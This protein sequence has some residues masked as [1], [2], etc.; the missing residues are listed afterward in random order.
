MIYFLSFSLFLI[1][2]SIWILSHSRDRRR[3]SIFFFSIVSFLIMLILSGCRGFNVGKDTP[4]YVRYFQSVNGIFNISSYTGR[5]EYFYRIYNCLIAQFFDSAHA[6]LFISTFITL[7][8]FYVTCFK[9]SHV[10][11]YS[12]LM[13]VFL[14]YYYNS[15][16]LLRQYIAMMICCIAYQY[17]AEKKYIKYILTTFIAVLF[18]SSAS[19]TFVLIF[20]TKLKINKKRRIIYIATAI[21]GALCFNKFLYVLIKILPKYASYITSDY[22]QEN[23]MGIIFKIFMWLLMFFLV[24]YM[25]FRARDGEENLGWN[26]IEYFCAL[27]A[28]SITIMALNGAILER[29]SYYFTIIY[30]IS[31][32]NSINKLKSRKMKYQIGFLVILSCISYNM[33]VLI[34]RPCWSGVIPYSF[35]Q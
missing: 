24:D 20:L 23:Q 35:W 22:Y 16:N 19:V 27:L 18:H 5:F 30:C 11:W 12:I 31:V 4:M 28:I 26:K 2:D 17:L 6:L 9:K 1:F 29:M 8:L 10:P 32:P 25:F 33:I 21:I 15:M 13:F 34:F 3:N 7:L 14:M